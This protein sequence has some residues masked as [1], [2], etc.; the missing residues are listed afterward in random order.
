MLSLLIALLTFFGAKRKGAS[1]AGAA[2]AALGAGA[3]SWYSID[4]Q[5]ENRWFFND[6][7]KL[8]SSIPPGAEVKYDSSTGQRY[9]TDEDG[10]NHF[11]KDT[12]VSP[13]GGT[14]W[15]SVINKGTETVGDVAKDW[16]AAGT[17]GA[18]AGLG[19]MG[20]ITSF[21]KNVPSWVWYGVGGLLL[22]KYV[23]D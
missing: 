11:L 4:P 1:T 12:T 6:D 3:L 17:V 22:Y 8:V 2:A 15:G 10:T 19:S 16:G 20:T 23:K 5:N 18:V 13:S 21:I 9:Y 14:N 7:K